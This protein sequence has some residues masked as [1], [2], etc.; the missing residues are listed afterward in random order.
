MPVIC[1]NMYVLISGNGALI[2][3][4]HICSPAEDLLREAGVRDCVIL[5]THEH[6]D[7]ISGVNWLRERYPCRVISTKSCAALIEDAKRSGAMTFGALFLLGHTEQERRAIEPWIVSDYVCQADE[8]YEGESKYSWHGISLTLKELQ[9]HSRGSQIIIA[10]N[11]SVFTG[12]NLVPGERVITRLP[13][14]S[15]ETYEAIVRPYLQALPDHSIVYP[16]HGEPN[17]ITDGGMRQGFDW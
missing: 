12:D 17:R 1:S 8:V 15:R 13:G 2:V 11:Q 10:D 3:D 4:P 5:L 7:H 6:F 14:G 9:G 16:G